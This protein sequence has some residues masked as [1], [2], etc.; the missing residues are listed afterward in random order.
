MKIRN[1]SFSQRV[2]PLELFERERGGDPDAHGFGGNADGTI[3]G[4]SFHLGLIAPAAGQS[5]RLPNPT[6]SGLSPVCCAGRRMLQHAP[7]SCE[8]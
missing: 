7:A 6:I 5:A 4:S 2:G 8:G 1:R 3:S